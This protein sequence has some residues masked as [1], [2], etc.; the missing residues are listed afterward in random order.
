MPAKIALF[1]SLN[2]ETHKYFYLCSQNGQNSFAYA[3]C[4]FDLI[5]DEI[6]KY[7]QLLNSPGMAWNFQIGICYV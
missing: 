1:Y 4:S 5:S 7:F 2:C 3:C 6:N